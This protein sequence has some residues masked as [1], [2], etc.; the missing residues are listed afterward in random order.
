MDDSP[1]HKS[2]PGQRVA[3][4]FLLFFTIGAIVIG[5]S[6]LLSN[7]Q[8]PFRTNVLSAPDANADLLKKLEQGSEDIM[9]KGRD[10]D[11][12]GL[13]DYDEQFIYKTSPYLKDSDS[14]GYDD[15]QE[16][17]SSHDPNCPQGKNCFNPLG[18]QSS[19]T[20]ATLGASLSPEA[21]AQ[22]ESIT[23]EQIREL[24]HAKGVAQDKLAT[25]SDAQLLELYKKS[26][27]QAIDKTK[28]APAQDALTAPASQAQQKIDPRTMDIT[29]VRRLML[30]TGKITKDAL[31]VIDDATLRTE[32]IKAYEQAQQQVQK[33]NPDLAQ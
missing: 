24:L 33:E 12:D 5:F 18:E 10:T 14:D 1:R 13:N 22:L 19:S 11:E 16:L 28:S 20:R 6:G 21:L 26:L 2:T 7:I 25:F 30:S 9:L 8:A 4:G 17:D 32:F 15:K 31:D 23:P 3:L 29:E 27:G